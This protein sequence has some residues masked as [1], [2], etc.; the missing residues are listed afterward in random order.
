MKRPH[1]QL[2]FIVYVL[3]LIF[4]NKHRKTQAANHPCHM[5]VSINGFKIRVHYLPD[6]YKYIRN[7]L[8]YKN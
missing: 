3:T 1:F 8:K 7:I 6:I 2:S 4:I 5:N